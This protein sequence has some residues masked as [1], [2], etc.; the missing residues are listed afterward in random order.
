MNGHLVGAEDVADFQYTANMNGLDDEREANNEVARSR[1]RR[2]VLAR[3][4]MT[5][6]RTLGDD[7]ARLSVGFHGRE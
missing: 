2:G 3:S 6:K 7:C 1:A 5:E 4:L